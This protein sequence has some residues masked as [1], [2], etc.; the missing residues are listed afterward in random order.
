M[1]SLVASLGKLCLA[2]TLLSDCPCCPLTTLQAVLTGGRETGTLEQQAGGA[3]P[4]QPHAPIDRLKSL[5]QRSSNSGRKT[6]TEGGA[7]AD[8]GGSTTGGAG[9]GSPTSQSRVDIGGAV[10]VMHVLCEFKFELDEP[11]LQAR[12]ALS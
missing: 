11:R 6:S 10:R 5:A 8:G 12:H 4:V 7:D 2:V 9:G 1:R 3:E